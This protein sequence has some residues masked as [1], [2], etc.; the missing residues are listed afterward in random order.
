MNTGPSVFVTLRRSDEQN[1]DLSDTNS[2]PQSQICIPS[3]AL[4][5]SA[6]ISIAECCVRVCPYSPC[7]RY[8]FGQMKPK[9]LLGLSPLGT[10]GTLPRRTI[11]F[12]SGQAYSQSR[13]QL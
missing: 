9:V 2:Q 5:A 12:F 4:R 13:E 11:G 7:V 6:V 8:L 1:V 10:S 3:A